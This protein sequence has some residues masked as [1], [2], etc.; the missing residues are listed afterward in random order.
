MTDKAQREEILIGSVN[1]QGFQ[2]PNG[3]YRMSLNSAAEAVGLNRRNAFEFLRSKTAERLLGE[4]YTGSISEVEIESEGRSRGQ[5]RISAI[6]LNIVA[7]YWLWQTSRGNKQAFALV[8]ALLE[9][10]LERRFDEAFGVARTEHERQERTAER[11]R[12]AEQDFQVL[13]EAYAEPDILREENERLREQ[14]R[15]LGGEPFQLPTE[16]DEG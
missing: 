15:Q 6:P 2:M 12:I 16:E 11:M 10:G 9:E 13:S 8:D 1:V 14:I 7:R 3:E 4:G 5:S